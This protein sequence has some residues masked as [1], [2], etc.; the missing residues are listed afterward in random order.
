MFTDTFLAHFLSPYNAGPMENPDAVGKAGDPECGDALEIS[1]KVREGVLEDVKFMVFGCAASIATSSMT[2]V[3]AKNKTL[4]Q[5]LALK[6]EH[7]VN[8]LGGLPDE[9]VHCSNLGI[10]ALHQAI[11]MYQGQQ[12]AEG[13]GV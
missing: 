3:L 4:E 12:L 2:T 10:G 9:K 1:I 7:V 8:A 11:K 13:A 5:A 6:E